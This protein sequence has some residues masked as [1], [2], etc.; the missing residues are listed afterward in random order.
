VRPAFLQ[1]KIRQRH[2]CASFDTM[3]DTGE[4]YLIHNAGL[5]II[6]MCFATERLGGQ[7]LSGF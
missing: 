1:L 2:K 3:T 6:N 5:Q 7:G 4:T